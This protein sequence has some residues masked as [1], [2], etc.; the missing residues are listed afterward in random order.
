[1]KITRKQLQEVTGQSAAV[2][3][4]FLKFLQSEKIIPEPGRATRVGKGK[5]DYVYDLS[6]LEDFDFQSWRLGI[7]EKL[8][9]IK[10][11]KDLENQEEFEESMEPLGDENYSS[12][13]DS[14]YG[15]F[16]LAGMFGEEEY[17]DFE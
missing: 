3:N 2:A 10:V 12:F 9:Q 11:E 5:T 4:G 14:D 13:E 15:E 1:M 16:S 17:E 7:E 8:H 6:S